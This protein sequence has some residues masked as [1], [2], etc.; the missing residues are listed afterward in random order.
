[1]MSKLIVEICRVEKVEKHPNA[2]KLSIVTIKGWNCITGLDQYKVGDLVIFCPPDSIIPESLIEKHNLEFLRKN[3]RVG[4]IKLRKVISQGLVLDISDLSPLV[5]VKEGI[6]V[7]NVLGIT[8]WEPPEANYSCQ[9]KRETVSQYFVKW[10]HKEITL[11][12]FIAKSFGLIK[13][14]LFKRKKKLNPYFDKYTDIENIKNYPNVLKDGELVVITEKIHG[15]NTRYGNLPKKS[16]WLNRKLYE[17]CY[18]SH[19]IQLCGNRGKHCFYGED[20]YGRIAERLQLDTKLPNGFVFYGEIYGKGVQDLTYGLDDISVQFF[21][22]KDV[23][24]GKYLDHDKFTDT[25]RLLQLP[26][27]PVLYYG[28]FSKEAIKEHTEGTSTVG[29]VT[30]GCIR[31]GCVIKP[32]IERIEHLGRVILKSISEEYLL[33][34]GGTENH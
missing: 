9:T 30:K 1:M 2:D 12:R 5:K 23:K 18:G 26:V 6:N 17:F 19:N 20:L 25:C 31:E 7:A 33:R 24:T 34:K 4:T 14:S 32:V 16:T 21:D 15:S 27:V 29:I 10:V 28:P 8:K 13:D 3:G 22:I 11:R